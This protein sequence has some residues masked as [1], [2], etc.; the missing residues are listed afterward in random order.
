MPWEQKHGS[1]QWNFT[2]LDLSQTAEKQYI[3]WNFK[4]ECINVTVGH[5]KYQEKSPFSD[6][7]TP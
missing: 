1:V 7:S 6:L 4:R 5:I 3:Q 2:T